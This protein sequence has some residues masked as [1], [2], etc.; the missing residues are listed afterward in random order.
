V[1]K[2]FAN[3]LFANKVRNNTPEESG[4][5]AATSLWQYDYALDHGYAVATAAYG[6]IEPDANDRGKEGPRGLAPEP[7]P[8]DWGSIGAWAWGMSRA[9]DYF[10]TNPRIDAKRVAVTGFSRIGKAALWA[11]ACDER[12]A[13]VISNCSGGGGAALS[14]RI[15]GETVENLAKGPGRWFCKNFGKYAGK[16]ADLP[17]DQHE[18]IA[19]VAPRPVLILSAT[20]DLWADPKGEFLAGVGADLVYRL[21]GADGI[22]QK[23]W[24]AAEKLLDSRIGYYLRV[25]KH[26]VTADDWRAMIAY[27]DKQW[28][29]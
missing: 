5:G 29:K 25:G 7:G 3:G 15:F 13:L 26:D 22:S 6:E 23:E 18:L 2:H 4:R 24:P 14:K 1:P 8:G 27:A 28:G 20:E 17:M 16:E 10:E 21:L 9:M 19:L 12:F 11:G